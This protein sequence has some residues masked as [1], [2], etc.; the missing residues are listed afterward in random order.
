MRN[1]GGKIMFTFREVMS[2]FGIGNDDDSKD[3]KENDRYY[4][5]PKDLAKVG[6]E[7]M[8]LE[9]RVEDLEQKVNKPKVA[10]KN[11]AKKSKLYYPNG[12]QPRK[13]N[14]GP[15]PGFKRKK[16]WA[17]AGPKKQK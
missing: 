12:K 6:A 16:T 5:N 11:V 8:R 9:K 13:S 7:I 4:A 1:I 10:K 17:K 3:I 15:A 14:R 2:K